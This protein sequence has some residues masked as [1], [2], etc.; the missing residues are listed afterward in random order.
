MSAGILTDQDLAVIELGG[1]ER[2]A[3]L[4]SMSGQELAD[5]AERI[6]GEIDSVNAG[7]KRIREVSN[8][9]LKALES[10]L[11]E[12][13]AIIAESGRIAYL[14]EVSD[15]V[16][17]INRDALEEL[18]ENLPE[19]LRPTMQM[20]Y[21]TVTQVRNAKKELR[22]S[23]VYLRQVLEFPPQTLGIRWRTIET[24]A[25]DE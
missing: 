15:G 10:K 23:G 13:E 18:G 24:G 17:K 8:Q 6:R 1:P 21:P 22:E 7:M 9:A 16:T 3:A 11:G 14:G 12:G 2:L 4:E 5:L 20:Q 25:V 19:K